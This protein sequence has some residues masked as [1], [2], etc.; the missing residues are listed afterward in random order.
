MTNSEN[1]CKKLGNLY[2]FK[3]LVKSDLIYIKE[4]SEEEELSDILMMA[5]NNIVV[6]EI[7]KKSNNYPIDKLLYVFISVIK[8]LL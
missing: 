1:V 6:I 4:N 3:E 7:K 5:G 2:F 8:Y